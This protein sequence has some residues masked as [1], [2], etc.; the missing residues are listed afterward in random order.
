MSSPLFCPRCLQCNE[1]GL[2]QK[3]RAKQECSRCGALFPLEAVLIS[4]DTLR[5]YI[6]QRNGEVDFLLTLF[7]KIKRN[8]L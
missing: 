7:E 2:I 3:G 4:E 5:T 6:K 1:L 8:K